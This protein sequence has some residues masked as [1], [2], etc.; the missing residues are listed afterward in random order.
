[1]TFV[2]DARKRAISMRPIHAVRCETANAAHGSSS[3]DGGA[4]S[5]RSA[6]MHTRSAY[7]FDPQR[8]RPAV[9]A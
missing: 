6:G 9:S 2:S 5:A 3:N 1:M 8:I 7:V 4:D